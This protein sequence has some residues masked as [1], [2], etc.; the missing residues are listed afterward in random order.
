M[1]YTEVKQVADEAGRGE[2][3]PV[4]SLADVYGKTVRLQDFAGRTVM[5]VFIGHSTSL[6]C[7]AHMAQLRRQYGRIQHLGGEVVVVSYEEGEAIKKLVAAHK[8]PFV[9]LLDPQKQVYQRYGMIYKEKGPVIRVRTVLKYL[10]LRLSGYPPQ[11]GP[12]QIRQ[13][14]GDVVI[15]QDGTIRFIHRS[16]YPDDRPD[17]AILLSNLQ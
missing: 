1:Q 4:F 2:P 11:Q 6:L 10:Q 5:L 14:G 16:Q 9:F 12:A 17:V 8:L 7:R 13:M 15:G 3:A